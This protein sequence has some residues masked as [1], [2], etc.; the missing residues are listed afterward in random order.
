MGQR[1]D[2][3]PDREPV[4]VSGQPQQQPVG[5][6]EQVHRGDPAVRDQHA[7]GQHRPLPPPGQPDQPGQH[8]V[9]RD[10]RDQ[11]PGLGQRAGQRLGPV[12]LPEPPVGR[13][14]RADHRDHRE[15]HPVRRQDPRRPAQ[16]VPADRPGRRVEQE[17]GQH[18]EHR[19]PDVEAGQHRP[20]GAGLGLPG[21]ERDVR[22]QHRAG[23][24]RTQPV[25]RRHHPPR[26]HRGHRT[27]QSG[28]D[29]VTSDGSTRGRMSRSSNTRW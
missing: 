10:L 18:E 2:R 1:G 7:A 19:D 6:V 24:H 11:R 26:T 5:Q 14:H 15:Q 29:A 4:Q 3:H 21:P 28:H 23:G 20:A 16:R 27:A 13:R 25:Q 12:P 17:A 9:E 8:R 22:Q